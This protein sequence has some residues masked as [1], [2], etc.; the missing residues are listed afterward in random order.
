MH[1]GQVAQ[2][3]S[4]LGS[5]ISPALVAPGLKSQSLYE[6]RTHPWQRRCIGLFD[7]AIRVVTILLEAASTISQ[8]ALAVESRRS[9]ADPPPF[10]GV[11]VVHDGGSGRPRCRAKGNRGLRGLLGKAL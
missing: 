5:P 1:R 8:F 10:R 11:C 4:E 7:L 3:R 2:C 6:F 9:Y